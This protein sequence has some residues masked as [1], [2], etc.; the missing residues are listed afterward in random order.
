MSDDNLDKKRT[1]VLKKVAW[2]SR[3]NQNSFEVP[4][5]HLEA[6]Q[7]VAEDSRKFQPYRTIG[8]SVWTG[9]LSRGK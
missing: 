9:P 5:S 8:R 3:H 7:M 4:E 1:D 6:A 2:C